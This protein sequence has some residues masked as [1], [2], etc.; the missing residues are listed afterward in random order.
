MTL[1]CLRGF[2]NV[3]LV[4]NSFLDGLKLGWVSLVKGI[5]LVLNFSLVPN[6]LVNGVFKYVDGWCS[7]ATCHIRSKLLLLLVQGMEVLL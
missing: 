7:E 5:L 2:C 3:E 1:P 6:V 4:Y